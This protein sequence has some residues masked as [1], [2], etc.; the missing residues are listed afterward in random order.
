VRFDRVARIAVGL[1]DQEPVL[2][3]WLLLAAGP[4]QREPA[5]QLVALEVEQELSADEP[6]VGILHRDPA[7]DVPD[8]HG[9]RP[10]VPLG[11]H[12]FEV[13][14]LDRVILDLHRQPLLGR[15]QRGTLRYRPRE[16]HAPP[17]EPQVVV[18]PARRVLLD[19]EQAGPRRVF[20][21]ERLGRAIGVSLRA[22]RA[23][24]ARRVLA[25][26]ATPT[27]RFPPKTAA[28]WAC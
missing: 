23:Q 20:A 26:L 3:V 2:A 13:G 14:V 4:D 27:H 12:P 11:D 19:D 8:D 21:A 22:V 18:E 5:A 25:H 7:A 6:R 15:V 9:A 28:F 24:T 17:L 16:Q 10:V 1:L